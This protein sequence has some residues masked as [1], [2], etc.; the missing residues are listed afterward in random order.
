M[1]V[2]YK[3]IMARLPAE[4][5]AQIEARAQELIA[6]YRTLQDLRKAH[7]LT[8]K[9]MAEKLGL[10]QA[11][12]SRLEQRS[13]VL[14]STIRSYIEAMGGTLDLVARF[15][16]RPPVVISGFAEISDEDD[17]HIEAKRA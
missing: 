13:D 4:R 12:V 10:D 2:S 14:L 3:E 8:Q 17:D 15:P 5:R 7:K 11:N 9:D 1:A 6:E 16:G